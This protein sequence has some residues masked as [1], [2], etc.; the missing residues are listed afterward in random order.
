M[1]IA[2]VPDR[3]AHDVVAV[4][5]SYHTAVTN[6]TIFVAANETVVATDD[7]LNPR[8][9]AAPGRC[10]RIDFHTAVPKMTAHDIVAIGQCRRAGEADLVIRRTADEAVGDA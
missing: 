1:L 6:K 2:I 4:A 10:P 7:P 9:A 5:Q 3:R 8:R